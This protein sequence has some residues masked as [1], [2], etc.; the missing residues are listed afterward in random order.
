MNSHELRQAFRL[1][2]A[3]IRRALDPE[4]AV[5]IRVMQEWELLMS[6]QLDDLT[7]AVTA[8]GTAVTA[9]IAKAGTPPAPDESVAL[10]AIATQ[11]QGLITQIN[12][13][14]APPAGP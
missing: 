9:L 1:E 14:L 8:L 10:E 7:A 2:V 11:M 13:A 6:K 3:E 5:F 12:A 4:R